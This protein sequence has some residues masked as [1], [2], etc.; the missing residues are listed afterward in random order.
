MTQLDDILKVLK[1][2]KDPRRVEDLRR[3]WPELYNAVIGALIPVNQG[4]LVDPPKVPAKYI[5]SPDERILTPKDGMVGGIS[6]FAGPKDQSTRDPKTK[7]PYNMGISG[8]NSDF[9]IDQWYCAMRFGYVGLVPNP[10]F[11]PGVAIKGADNIGLSQSEK[12]RLKALLPKLRLKV[13]NKSNGKAII[14]R[15]ADFGPGIIK[16][17]RVIDVSE[18]AIKTLGATTDTQVVV[19][20]V[21]PATPLGPV[22]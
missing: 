3:V 8:E 6:W 13:T 19:E 20:W 11:P 15:P 4:P 7:K 17:F 9:P 2:N 10:A 16:P 5:P 12:W 21:D 18:H 1:D 14:V 22:A